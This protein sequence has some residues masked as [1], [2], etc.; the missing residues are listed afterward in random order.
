MVRRLGTQKCGEPDPATAEALEAIV[1]I[2]RL[3]AIGDKILRPDIKSWVD[4]LNG[5]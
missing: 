5:S 3:E 2:D 4:L 1:D